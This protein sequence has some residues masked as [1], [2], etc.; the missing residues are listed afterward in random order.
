MK[1]MKMIDSSVSIKLDIAELL[2]RSKFW[3]S[4]EEIAMY[5]KLDKKTIHRY[6]SELSE[7]IL[8][9]NKDT[10]SFES[11][12]GKG[13]KLHVSNSN[14]Y[15]EFK[16]FLVDNTLT[17]NIVKALALQKG[18]SLI[19]LANDN[20]VSESTI[21]R[22][23]QQLKEY[24][25]HMDIS[26]TSRNGRYSIVGD[27]KEIR[28]F[29]FII[30]WKVYR[31]RTW[32]FSEIDH[33]KMI[34]LINNLT[35]TTKF[36]IKEINKQKTAFI[37]SICLLRYKKGEKIDLSKIDSKIISLC[38][39]I[40]KHTDIS[41]QLSSYYFLPKNESHFFILLLLSHP[42]IY[43]VSLEHRSVAELCKN[44][45]P[46]FYTTTISVLNRLLEHFELKASTTVYSQILNTLLANHLYLY[47]NPGTHYDNNG[48]YI[49]PTLY[50]SYPVL[51]GKIK[52]FI[53]HT[54]PKDLLSS[55][56]NAELLSSSYFFALAQLMDIKKYEPKI[57]VYFESDFTL[58]TEKSIINYVYSYLRS[59]YNIEFFTNYFE[60]N[61][62]EIDLIVSTSAAPTLIEL[63]RN[64]P[65][66]NI[67]PETMRKDIATIEYEIE[68]I[69][70]NKYLSMGITI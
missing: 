26:I 67:F 3:V 51:I 60:T 29:L 40:D 38:E 23:I 25:D 47:M 12:K 61:S 15:R 35:Q 55:D 2:Y 57:C 1:M 63:Q 9:F 45:E 20:F 41:K 32:P 30:L 13:V 42:G 70:E 33:N 14:D 16:Q 50:S 18:N 53:K 10:L 56:Y 48:Y 22:K 37:L 44:I 52:D 17:I 36:Q 49:Y 64:I 69:I 34:T 24:V 46:E 68:K 62:S 39:V 59:S 5:L 28:M 43:S 65:H 54:V 31:G 66:I 7:D 21:R 11:I 4:S 27:E 58:I 19:S 6:T 8:D